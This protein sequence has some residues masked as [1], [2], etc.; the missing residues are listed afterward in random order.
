MIFFGRKNVMILLE[1]RGVIDLGTGSK[2]WLPQGLQQTNLFKKNINP[3]KIPCLF[4]D[5]IAYSEQVGRCLQ[6]GGKQG[7]INI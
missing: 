2:P 1:E 5:S 7:E 3:Q 4:N 6:E